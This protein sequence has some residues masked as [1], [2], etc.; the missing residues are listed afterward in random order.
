MNE[1]IVKIKDNEHWWGGCSDDG[2]VMPFDK[3]TVFS[4]NID[5]NPTD[6]QAVPL[7]LSDQGR[8]IWSE[9]G[10]SFEI[11][12]G[13]IKLLSY[14]NEILL[15]EGYENLSGAFKAASKNYFP[16][17]NKYPALKFFD[18]PQ[19][20]TWIELTFNQTQ[21]NIMNYA[22]QLID[23]GYPA[24]VLMID[25]GWSPYYGK[26]DFSHE[27]FSNPK[28]MVQKLHNMG[29]SVM[30]W[31]CP[32]ITPDTLPFRE[33]SKQDFLVKDKTG[34]TAI[35]Q[36]WNGFSAMLDLSNPDVVNWFKSQLD[37]LMNEYGIDGFKF[38]AGD[39]RYY[40]DDDIT[41]GNFDGN[42]MSE[43]WGKLGKEYTFNEYRACFKCGGY[44]L[45][46]R[47]RDK[48]HSWDDN[49]I[50]SLI[51]CALAQSIIGHPYVCP[52]MI[53][54]GE[55]Q[56][57]LANA[58]NLDQELFVRYSQCAAL[59]PMMQYSAAP[60][61]VL[62]K[63]YAK[64]CL[65]SAKTHMDYADEIVNLVKQSSETGEPII[66]YLE[67]VFPHQGLHK[68]IDQFMLG[69]EL[70]V[71]PVLEKGATSRTVTFP[72]GKWKDLNGNVY[73]GGTVTID[74]PLEVLPIFFLEE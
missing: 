7:L 48:A 58:D 30:L 9:N 13:E 69:E 34:N 4:Q 14:K 64:L 54:G 37:Y 47:L 42:A 66:R 17:S 52:D 41:Y 33:L 26:W 43:A 62:D 50:S 36:W 12:N 5:P 70:M 31:I 49:G 63:E 46:Q 45:V 2:M 71:A 68:I 74:A 57:F 73:N 60:W 44:A 15:H 29:F 39:A 11:S 18:V 35:R 6:N 10:F 23:N 3:N 59:M 27:A 21:D 19:Y 20:N 16:P 55:Y 61:R 67:Y 8:F 56:N 72:K 65:E 22:N 24:G 1:L 28:E 40:Y 38:D 32:F 53:G 25:D 51:P